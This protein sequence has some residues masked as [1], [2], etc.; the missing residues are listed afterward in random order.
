MFEAGKTQK[1]KITNGNTMKIIGSLWDGFCSYSLE[2][3]VMA[4]RL[5]LTL[6]TIFCSVGQFKR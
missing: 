6:L 4:L 1:N 3:W 5:N 2:K